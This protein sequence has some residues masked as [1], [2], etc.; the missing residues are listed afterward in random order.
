MKKVAF[1]AAV[2]LAAVSS[3][4]S[5]AE[6]I[7]N[8]DFEA[9]PVTPS[10]PTPFT[11]SPGAE[12]FVVEGIAY[13]GC[14]ATTGTTEQYANQFATFGSANLPNISTLSQSFGTIAGAAYLFSFD[15]GALGAA[16]LSQTIT[17]QIID[18]ATNDILVD[19]S[20]T[21]ETSSDLGSAFNFVERNFIASG[22]SARVAFSA[23]PL[24]AIDVDLVLDNVSVTGPAVPEPATWAFMIVGFG[25]V[26]GAMRR[27]RRRVMAPA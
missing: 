24:Q 2:A 26:G 6:L 25:A 17:A 11:V 9:N 20:A 15:W 8:G 14:C 5:A 23:A 19:F 12:I 1:A 27:T 13:Q 21:D 4:A 3:G 16:G 7:V 18:N 10:L 22:V